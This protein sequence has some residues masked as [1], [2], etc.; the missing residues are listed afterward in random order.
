MRN[1]KFIDTF[2]GNQAVNYNLKLTNAY[3]QIQHH[4]LLE[5]IFIQILINLFDGGF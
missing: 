1:T 3:F 4:F 2:Q 5:K